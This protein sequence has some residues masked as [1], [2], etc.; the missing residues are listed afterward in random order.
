MSVVHHDH[1]RLALVHSFETPGNSFQVGDALRN[2][3]RRN[4]HPESGTRGR[5]DIE[6]VDTPD[7]AGRHGKP[8]LPELEIETEPLKGRI[9]VPRPNL[10]VVAKAVP[11]S[12][13]RGCGLDIVAVLVLA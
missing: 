10:A 5:Q 1:E 6:D 11:Q 13:G 4:S 2:I 3:L 12:L 7:Q 8:V 9:D